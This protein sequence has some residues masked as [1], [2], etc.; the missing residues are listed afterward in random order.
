VGPVRCGRAVSLGDQQPLS[1]DSMEQ[2]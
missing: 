1:V 2:G